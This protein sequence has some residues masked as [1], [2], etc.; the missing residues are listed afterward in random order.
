MPARFFAVTSSLQALFL[1]VVVFTPAAQAGQ[2]GPNAVAAPAGTVV[3]ASAP[4]GPCRPPSTPA[5][6][7]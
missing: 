3:K 2:P 6:R 1:A 7:R 4:L 5:R